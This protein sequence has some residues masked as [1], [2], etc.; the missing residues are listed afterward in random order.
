MSQ[1]DEAGQ[2]IDQN[3]YITK[4]GIDLVPFLE[5]TNYDAVLSINKDSKK[6]YSPFVDPL[7]PLYFYPTGCFYDR[8]NISPYIAYIK[9]DNQVHQDVV[10]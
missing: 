1:L 4:K 5:Y 9:D 10:T 2:W 8:D 7:S 3:Y 6:F